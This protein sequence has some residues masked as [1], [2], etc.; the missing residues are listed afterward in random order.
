MLGLDPKLVVHH[1]VVN[2]KIKPVR[3]KLHKMHPK[4][5][6]LVKVELEKMLEAKVIN[7][8]DYS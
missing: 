3:Q 2:P 1:L 8:I 5:A 4:V 6:L 7:P